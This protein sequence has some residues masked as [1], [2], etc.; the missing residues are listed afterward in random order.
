MPILSSLGSIRVCQ[1]YL[2]MSIASLI[3]SKTEKIDSFYAFVNMYCLLCFQKQTI[4]F[5]SSNFS[6]MPCREVDKHIQS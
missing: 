2:V 5:K 6:L 3:L 1:N 4:I